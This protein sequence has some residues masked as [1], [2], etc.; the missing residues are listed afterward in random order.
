MVQLYLPLAGLISVVFWLGVL[1][2]R[3][4]SLEARVRDLDG[5]AAGERLAI[6]ETKL[7]GI[8]D[9][10]RGFDNRFGELA[11]AIALAPATPYQPR[12]RGAKL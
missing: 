6:L 4:K 8:A 5:G 11:K 1:S 12:P 9:Q 3:V 2:Q 7:T 10:L